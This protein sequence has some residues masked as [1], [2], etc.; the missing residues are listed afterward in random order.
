MKTLGGPSSA[1]IAWARADLRRR[2]RSILVLGLLAGL[3]AGLALASIAGAR[4][5]ASAFPRLRARTLAAD[6]AVFPGQVGVNQA[7][8]SRLQAK[9]YVTNL[10]RWDLSFGTL[11]GE[12]G[13]VLFIPVDGHWLGDVDRPVIVKGRMFRRTASDE[14]VVD[15]VAHREHGVDV[16]DV[17]PYRPFGPDQDDTSGK[18]PTGPS[19]KLRVVGVTRDVNEFLFNPEGSIFVSPGV[20]TRYGSQMELVQNGHVRLRHGAKDIPALQRDADRLVHAGTPILDFHGVARRI[21]TSFTIERTALLLLGTAVAAAGLVFIGQALSRS[22]TFIDEDSAALHAMGFTRRELALAAALPHVVVAAVAVLVALT[23]AVLAS[24]RFPIGLAGRVDP[25]KG[26][27]ADWRVLAPGLILTALVL[28]GG[29]WLVSW[30]RAT[31]HG[32]GAV[33]SRRSRLAGAIRR[34]APLP[35]GLGTAMAIEP[36]QGHQRVPVRPALAG[37]VVGVLGLVGTFTI[38]HGLRD[39]LRHHDRAG[40]TWDATVEPR[41]GDQQ[42]TQIAGRLLRRIERVPGVG[43][44]T[45]LRRRLSQVGGAGVALFSIRPTA[46]D[47]RL[48]TLSGRAPRGRDEAAIGPSTARQIHAKVGDVVTVGER[49]RRMR[50]VGTALFPT[51]VHSSFDEGLWVNP[52]AFNS[53]SRDN[54]PKQEDRYVSVRWRSGVDK[55]RALKRLQADIGPVAEAVAPAQVPVELTNLRNVHTVPIVLAV[56]L[57]SLAIST[58]THTLVASVRRRRNELAILRALGFTRRMTRTIISTQSTVVGVVGLVIGLPLGFVV[59]RIGWIWVAAKVPLRFVSPITLA[60]ALI[61]VPSVIVL[62]NLLAALP[63]RRAAHLRPA[64]ALR[65]E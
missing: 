43:A 50:L 34:H 36:G 45:E 9:S 65:T 22:L 30:T 23:T 62:A 41:S 2:W 14:V 52:E 6:A 19:M 59:G 35:I 37:A 4:R 10:A 15:E 5:T 46:G 61:V 18:P 44:A 24:P 40:V 13:A 58:L 32:S 51:D 57:A 47:L 49:H 60:L 48:M 63:G 12:P 17:L 56:F 31:S 8:W 28:V 39:A 55:G 3:T 26:F 29:T 38:D 64:E 42:P 27:R 7:D 16:G 11:G 33:G 21:T 20:L 25:D 53:A 54:G 1:A